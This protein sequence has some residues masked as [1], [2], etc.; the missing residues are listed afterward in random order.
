MRNLIALVSALQVA[1]AASI[2][3]EIE[4]RAQQQSGDACTT[5]SQVIQSHAVKGK[6]L[7]VEGQLVHDCLTALPF[8][9]QLTGQFL[10]E[11]RKYVQFQST[12]EALKA[13]PKSYLSP[14][15]DIL[16]GLDTIAK[17]TYQSQY[18]FDMALTSLF[19][20]ANDGHLDFQLCSIRP[21]LLFFRDPSYQMVSVS[22]DGLAAPALYL[23]NDASL[24]TSKTVKVSPVTTING[25]KATDYLNDVASRITS[26]DP[27]ARWNQLF[28]SY[29]A[30]A[31]SGS[32]AYA[33]G[34]F[35]TSVVWPGTNSTVVGFANGT[36]L[37][38]DTVT[39]MPAAI[40]SG[41]NFPQN[42]EDLFENICVPSSATTANNQKKRSLPSWKFPDNYDD[43]TQEKQTQLPTSGPHYNQMNGYYLDAQTAVMFIPSFNGEGQPDDQDGKFADVATKLVSD[44]VKSGRKRIIIDVSGNGG[45]NINRGFDLFRLFFPNGFPY[46]ATKF[47]RTDAT[48]AIDTIFASLTQ[49]EAS[50]DPWGWKGQVRPDQ[51]TRVSS[52]DDFLGSGALELG[53]PVSSLFANF[54]FAAFSSK[55][56]PVRGFGAVPLSDGMC[57]ST[58]TTFVNLMTNVGGVRTVAFGGRPSTGPMQ[59]MGGVRGSQSYEI[60]DIYAKVSQADAMLHQKP[61]LLSSD[62]TAKWQASRPINSSAFPL[63]LGSGSV[64]FRNAYQQGDDS[65]PLQFAYQAADCRLF[66]T[67]DNYAKPAT[68]WQAAADAVWGGKGCVQGSTGAQ[69]SRA[70]AAAHPNQSGGSGSGS[71]GDSKKK[72][73]ANNNREYAYGGLGAAMLILA[74]TWS[75]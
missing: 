1:G 31:S 53:V 43:E 38:I 3:P 39:I 65:T 33:Y 18:D 56:S 17:T 15:I 14:A 32:P 21:T 46:S 57:A 48:N 8:K 28:P 63:V 75:L 70:Y 45:G 20:S 25:K 44:A 10:T 67:F 72:N 24:I 50:N 37:A 23:W 66:Y 4:P 54:D 2:S 26:Q 64:N 22:V 34:K 60:D 5:L 19:N 68:Q 42:A 30:L 61:S 40:I 51:K 59:I 12:L 36:T 55:D 69:G 16:G 74:I 52:L 47:R 6:D 41:G 11:L 73:G 49:Q 62:M 7:L 9:S 29:A 13:P 71:D 58:C 35:T 27:D